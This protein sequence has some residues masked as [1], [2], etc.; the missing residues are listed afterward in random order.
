MLDSIAEPVSSAGSAASTRMAAGTGGYLAHASRRAAC[1]AA[2]GAASVTI[3]GFEEGGYFSTTWGWTALALSAAAAFGVLS[4]GLPG[5]RPT[6]WLSP[7]ALAGLAIWTLASQ[8]WGVPGTE[9]AHEAGRAGMYLAALGAFLIVVER[10]TVKAL[11][12]GVLSGIVA[13]ECHAIGQRAVERGD[14]DPTQGT[15]LT[16]PIGYAN[17]LGILAAMGTLL[18]LGFAWEERRAPVRAVFVMAGLT[19]I[20]ALALTSSRGAV[21]ALGVGLVVLAAARLRGGSQFLAI[22]LAIVIVGALV[23]VARP[24]LGDRTAYWRVA[25]SD[26]TRHPVLGSG[27]GSFDDVWYS[28]RPIPANV[29]DAHSLYLEVLAELGP[30][31]LILVLAVLVPPLVASVRSPGAGVAP[32][33]AAAYAAFL[34]HAGLDWDWEVPA[35]TLAALA[36]G[37]ALL[38]SLRRPDAL[39]VS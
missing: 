3:V 5:L 33:A 15:L 29:R 39:S 23:A 25:A 30:I 9:A 26:V 32:I 28:N 37:A 20:V 34:V 1:S 38:I 17:A 13:L 31:G 36:C 10:T 4:R 2:L 16:G 27:A 24:S 21:L 8:L 22:A 14:P 7:V 19:S 6:G 11:L 35:T 12:I 18:A